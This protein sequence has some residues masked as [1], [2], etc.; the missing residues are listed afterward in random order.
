MLAL[1][2]ILVVVER[3]GGRDQCVHAGVPFYL[4]QSLLLW[5]GG[6]DPLDPRTENAMLALVSILVVVE[7][8]GGLAIGSLGSN[9]IGLVSI[10]VVVER[11]GGHRGTRECVVPFDWFQSLLLWNGG[12]DSGAASRAGLDTAGFNPCCC[13]TGGRTPGADANRGRWWGVSILVVVER[14]GG[15]VSA[16]GR[17]G[18]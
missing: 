4:F 16:S 1:V 10:L 9:A 14:G 8:G 6:A 13:G 3:G 5:N 7:R 11:G 12:A 2:S 15:A 18:E 17:R